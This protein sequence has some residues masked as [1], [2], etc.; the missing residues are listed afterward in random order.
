MGFLVGS[1]YFYKVSRSSK[2]FLIF[3][4]GNNFLKHLIFSDPTIIHCKVCRGKDCADG[5]NAESKP[6]TLGE[7]SCFYANDS[8]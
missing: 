4:L 1:V 3:Q 6:C 5:E 7:K 2:I 8:K